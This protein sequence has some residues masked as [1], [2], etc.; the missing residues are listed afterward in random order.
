MCFLV[1]G[2][3]YTNIVGPP[4]TECSVFGGI[5]AAIFDF[6]VTMVPLLH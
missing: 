4:A 3:V 1:V 5:L 2:N 6:R